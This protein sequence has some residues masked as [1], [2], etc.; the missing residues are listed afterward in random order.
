MTED[1]QWF[2]VGVV[3][4]PEAERDVARAVFDEAP[5]RF[6]DIMGADTPE[7]HDQ[8]P[9]GSHTAYSAHL[10]EREAEQFA[11]ASNLRY[12]EENRRHHN[13]TSVQT[14]DPYLPRPNA[15]HVLQGEVDAYPTLTGV[16]IPIADIDMGNTSLARAVKNVTL[17]NK[18]YFADTDPTGEIYSTTA[19]HG[20]LTMGNAIPFGGQVIDALAI[21]GNDTTTDAYMA[22]AITWSL[23]QG[24]RLVNM[25]LTLGSYSSVV[26]DALAAGANQDVAFFIAAGNDGQ[27]IQRWPS[28]ANTYMPYVHAVMAYDMSTGHRCSFSNY[29]PWQ[30]GTAP[31]ELVFT[32]NWDGTIVQ[33]AGTSAATPHTLQ[34][35]A[36]I[37]SAN[38]S[39]KQAAAAL[40]ATVRD[41]GIGEDGKL[42]SMQA[43]LRWLGKEP[44]IVVGST[45]KPQ[46]GAA[47]PLW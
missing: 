3:K 45:T 35:A 20:C 37:M 10:T 36:R 38:V 30:T 46:Q 15:Q 34:L 2:N 40:A 29:G 27:R 21:D 44:P 24:A 14:L 23:G 47:L 43:A 12:I 9:V 5:E 26:N 13:V 17:L 8:Y 28:S 1:R 19:N 39:A 16:G 18:A 6:Y 22:N 11:R 41:V 33:W 31:G 7:D 4:L 32:T 25:S 42:Y